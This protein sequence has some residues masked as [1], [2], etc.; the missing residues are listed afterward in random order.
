MKSSMRQLCDSETFIRPLGFLI[1]SHE[2][3]FDISF[4][5]ESKG[6]CPRRPNPRS[7][8]GID[9]VFAMFAK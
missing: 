1:S 8:R 6:P 5:T 4:A 7:E 2:E 3:N 9:E